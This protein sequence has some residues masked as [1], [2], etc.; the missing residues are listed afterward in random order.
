[1][2]Y[3][4]SFNQNPKCNDPVWYFIAEYSL[5]AGTVG[6]N[7]ESEF[8]AG[9]L[10]QTMQ[11]LGIP[12]ECLQ[13]I[14]RTVAGFAKEA[15]VHFNQGRCELPVS[16]RLFCPQKMVEDV[17]SEKISNHCNEERSMEPAQSIRRAET[18]TNGGWGYFLIER[19]GDFPHGSSRNCHNMID[20]YLYKEG[21]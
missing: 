11:N 3:A 17:N 9:T 1:M 5:S 8:T 2:K 4:N 19:G 12:P 6:K 20:L 16:V 18:K 7:I 15:T 10:F 21:E 14:E 13:K